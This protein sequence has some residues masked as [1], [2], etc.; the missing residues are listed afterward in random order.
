MAPSERSVA[1]LEPDDRTALLASLNE[2]TFDERREAIHKA[3]RFGDFVEAFAFM[4]RVAVLAEKLDHYPE[5]INVYDR[6]VIL[7][8][9]HDAGGV[10]TRDVELAR[11]ID[12][13]FANSPA[14][15]DVSAPD[16]SS[17]A[18]LVWI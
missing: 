17:A 12:R 5:W 18:P 9:A 11:M 14:A 3:Y 8:T 7:L 13:A 2:W 16:Y 6:V 1:R 4:T 10:S 15:T